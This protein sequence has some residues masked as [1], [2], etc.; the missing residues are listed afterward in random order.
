[1]KIPESPH[2][3]GRKNPKVAEKPP[4]SAM[5][6]IWHA[7]CVGKGIRGSIPRTMQKEDMTVNTASTISNRFAA[8]ASAFVLSLVLIAGTVSVP[9]KADAASRTAIVSALA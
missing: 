6:P 4:N 5:I 8:A 3:Y 9:A 1:V 7:S 2:S